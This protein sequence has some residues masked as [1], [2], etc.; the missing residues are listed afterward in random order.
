MQTDARRQTPLVLLH[1]GENDRRASPRSMRS[2][3]PQAQGK[4]TATPAGCTGC[5]GLQCIPLRWRVTPPG[6]AGPK[7]ASAQPRPASATRWAPG[8]QET[9][10]S[11]SAAIPRF[12]WP[13]LHAGSIKTCAV[14]LTGD[15]GGWLCCSGHRKQCI[16]I[17]FAHINSIAIE[18][19]FKRS[20]TRRRPP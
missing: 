15:T 10:R 20:H 2:S 18:R 6:H 16:C 11:P 8:L 13:G 12:G 5:G 14:A 4:F 9:R 7:Q 1:L 3:P 17:D 19:R